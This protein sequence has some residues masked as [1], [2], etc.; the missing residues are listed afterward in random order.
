M[1]SKVFEIPYYAVIFTSKRSPGDSGYSEMAQNLL[2]E[3]EKIEG[4]LGADSVRDTE[5][6]GI[7][8]SYWRTLEAIDKWKNHTLHIEGK[9]MDIKQWYEEYSI[10]ICKVEYEK[11]FESSV[12]KPDGIG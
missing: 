5:G 4:F 1:I 8:V 12:L 2:I 3:A 10:R 7:T 11:F 9:K 6:I